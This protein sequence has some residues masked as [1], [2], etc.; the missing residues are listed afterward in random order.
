MEKNNIVSKNNKTYRKDAS[1]FF[2]AGELCRRSLIAVITLGNC[3]NTD[4]LCS[5]VEATKFVHIQVKTFIPGSKTCSV[6]IKAEI[7]YGSNFFWILGGI[8]KPKQNSN[9]EYYIIPS[10]EMAQNVSTANKAWLKAPGKKGQK[11]N[12]SNVRT[13]HIPPYKNFI[14]WDIAEYKNRWDLIEKTLK[15]Q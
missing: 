9:F 3:P 11:H 12:D 15:A 6:G 5:N 4:I 14:S 8:P 10:S 2:I 13:V 1:Q 7:N